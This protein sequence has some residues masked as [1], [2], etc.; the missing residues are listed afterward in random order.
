MS[1]IKVTWPGSG[2]GVLFVYPET[3][4]GRRTP[5]LLQ[6]VTTG[7]VGKGRNYRI[8]YLEAGKSIECQGGC[9]DPVKVNLKGLEF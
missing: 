8:S 1:A 7:R 6:A 5:A 3:A 4:R 2:K 9:V